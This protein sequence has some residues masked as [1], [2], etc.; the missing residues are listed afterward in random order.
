[1]HKETGEI[2]KLE[3]IPKEQTKYWSDP[4]SVGDVVKLFGVPLKIVEVNIMTG[5]IVL[6]HYHQLQ[7]EADRQHIIKD[8]K[9]AEKGYIDK[10]FG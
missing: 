10:L 8:V 6:K 4:F 5:K 3:L 2:R 1:M 9:R 7:D